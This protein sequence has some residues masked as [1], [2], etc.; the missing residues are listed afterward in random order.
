MFI[1]NLLLFGNCKVK[2]DNFDNFGCENMHYNQLVALR[3]SAVW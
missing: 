2:I 3:L 1:F